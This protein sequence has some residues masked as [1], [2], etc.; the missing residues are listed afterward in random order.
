MAPKMESRNVKGTLCRLHIVA[1]QS[2]KLRF[3]LKKL[4]KV[5]NVK[6]FS[7]N[8]EASRFYAELLFA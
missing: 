2:K 4:H 8:K 1:V 3:F 7:F 5:L 6:F